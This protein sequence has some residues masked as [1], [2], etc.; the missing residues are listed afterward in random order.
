MLSWPSIRVMVWGL[1]AGDR[2]SPARRPRCH[3]AGRPSAWAL[4]KPRGTASLDRSLPGRMRMGDRVSANPTSVVRRALALFEPFGVHSPRGAVACG[5]G[6]GSHGGRRRRKLDASR[7]GLPV[8][9]LPAARSC[10]R[11]GGRRSAMKRPA[12]RARRVRRGAEWRHASVKP[13]SWA[14]GS[15]CRGGEGQLSMF[16]HPR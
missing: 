1:A 2:L 14:F 6:G 3:T 7:A 16:S 5:V 4:P 15:S 12:S 9:R 13:C 10:T 8:P 11:S